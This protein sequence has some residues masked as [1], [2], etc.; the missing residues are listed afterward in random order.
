MSDLNGI[1]IQDQAQSVLRRSVRRDL[2]QD[3][4]NGSTSLRERARHEG[5]TV[6]SLRVKPRVRR[7][8]IGVAVIAVLVTGVAFAVTASSETEHAVSTS[9]RVLAVT[10]TSLENVNAFQMAREYTG[11]IVARRTSQLGFESAGKL[12]QIYADEG[13]SVT[14][15]TP[16]AQLDTEHLEVRRRQVVARRA[17]AAAKLDE[18]VAGPRDE[19]I[20]VARA[21]IKRHEAQVDLLRLQTARYKR[22]LAENAASQ[23][24]YEQYTFGLTAREAQL[25]EARHKL[26]ELLNG[27]RKEQLSSQRAVVAELDARLADIDVDLRKSTLKAPFDGTIARRLADDGTVVEVGQPIFRLVESQVL[28]A[29]IGLPVRTASRLAKAS[30]QRV[31]IGDHSFAATVASRFPEVDPATRTR[32][33]VLRLDDSAAKHLVHGQ[34]V[35]LELDET[36]EATGFWLPST[37]LTKGMRGLWTAFVVVKTG[38]QSSIQDNLQRVER[39]DIEVLHTES[40]RVLVRGTLNSG[41]RVITS[42]THRVVAGQLVHLTK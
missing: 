20:A 8:A 5:R 28:E 32:M 6:R 19:G 12:L 1:A 16:L 11:T 15:G 26:E 23:G 39:R 40:D 18:M 17:Q 34:V 21:Q 29:W 13:D 24:D 4:R 31:T 27:T 38:S 35:R 9:P 33:V 25:N 2:E 36:V 30:I 22:L 42:G 10:T 41:D 14:A 37:A 7:V 3:E